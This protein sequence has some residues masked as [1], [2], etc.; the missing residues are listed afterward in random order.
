MGFEALS[1]VTP[2][3]HPGLYAAAHFMGGEAGPGILFSDL[4]FKD[5]IRLKNFFYVR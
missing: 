4:F 1:D 2:G 5:I 3:L